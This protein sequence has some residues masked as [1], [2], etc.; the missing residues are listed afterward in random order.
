MRSHIAELEHE[1]A[2][3]NIEGIQINKEK[4]K[5]YISHHPVR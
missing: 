4:L 1:V 2:L 3:E 5:K